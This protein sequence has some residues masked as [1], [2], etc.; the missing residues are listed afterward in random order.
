MTSGLQA[1]VEAAAST[2]DR[3]VLIEEY[4]TGDEHSF[5][6]VSIGGRAVFRS[7]HY[8]PSPLGCCATMDPVVSG[9]AA[10]GRRA[11]VR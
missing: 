1:A 8:Y 3:P 5:E 10:R 2:P 9:S 11:P 6:T 7:S 4:M